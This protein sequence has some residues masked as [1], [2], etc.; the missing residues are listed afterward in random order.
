VKR[1]VLDLDELRRL[2]A[3][4]DTSRQR[5]EHSQRAL[6]D[7]A[8]SLHLDRGEPDPPMAG[9]L[10]ALF[11]ALDGPLGLPMVARHLDF[12]TRLLRETLRLAAEAA[13]P[14]GKYSHE[15]L[16]PFLQRVGGRID[17]PAAAVLESLLVGGPTKGQRHPSADPAPREK[18][19][20]KAPEHGSGQEL[21]TGSG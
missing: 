5:V 19:T 2:E 15:D 13:G 8:A 7:I 17:L 11:A 21:L 14:D 20:K 18:V 6:R 12:D 9:H 4:T 3:L 10:G 1:I 16:I